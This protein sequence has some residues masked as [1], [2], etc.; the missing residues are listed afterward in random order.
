MNW[1]ICEPI[2]EFITTKT[3]KT[4]EDSMSRLSKLHL[5]KQFLAVFG[6][7]KNIE[8][9]NDVAASYHDYKVKSENYQ[10]AKNIFFQALEDNG[11]GQWIRKSKESDLFNIDTLEIN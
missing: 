5:F 8:L 10:V 6:N 2:V 3:G 9:C 1:I 4:T 11:R 7:L